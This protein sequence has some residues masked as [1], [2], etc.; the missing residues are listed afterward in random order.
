VR[1]GKRQIEQL[2]QAA[3]AEV[4][5]VRVRPSCSLTREVISHLGTLDF[6]AGKENVV[7]LAGG[8]AAPGQTT[9]VRPEFISDICGGLSRRRRVICLGHCRHA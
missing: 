5:T 8:L 3:A 4:R 6:V 2:A 9:H 7:Y 1:I